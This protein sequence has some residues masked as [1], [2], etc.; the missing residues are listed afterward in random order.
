M[1]QSSPRLKLNSSSSVSAEE[2]SADEAREKSVTYNRDKENFFNFSMKIIWKSPSRCP[3]GAKEEHKKVSRQITT[4]RRLKG[5][6]N[7]HFIFLLLLL[8][9]AATFLWAPQLIIK[10]KL[11]W[12]TFNKSRQT[13]KI[14]ISFSE[15]LNF[16]E[17]GKNK[18]IKVF[19][20]SK[21]VPYLSY[22][23][24]LY[25]RKWPQLPP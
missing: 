4:R 24:T 19:F 9:A 6:S 8:A 12:K 23:L 3:A 2:Q 13:R 11:R 5:D 17:K 21:S 10:L 16:F 15:G 1:I 25:L 22:Q 7:F 14:E 20:A 18:I